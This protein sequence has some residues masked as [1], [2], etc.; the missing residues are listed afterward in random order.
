MADD[1]GQTAGRVSYFVTVRTFE[2]KSVFHDATKAEMLV[3]V[4]E[5]KRRQVGFKKYAYVVLPDHYHV[6]LGGGADSQSVAD[7]VLAVNTAIERLVEEPDTGQPLWDAEPEVL[8]DETI[9]LPEG[10]IAN[11]SYPL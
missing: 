11:F 5:T 6:L 4:I 3:D 7:V 8:V 1:D 9:T 2:C 10:E